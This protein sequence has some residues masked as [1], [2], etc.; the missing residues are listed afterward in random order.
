MKLSSDHF[1]CVAVIGRQLAPFKLKKPIR[2]RHQLRARFTNPQQD[3][4]PGNREIELGEIPLG[5]LDA[6]RLQMNGVGRQLS[7]LSFA[8]IEV[9]AGV[10]NGK[11]CDEERERHR[12]EF[13]FS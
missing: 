11:R 9:G 4:T 6:A 8:L 5:S 2:S 12:G 10:C 1:V 13:T 3:R 7:Q